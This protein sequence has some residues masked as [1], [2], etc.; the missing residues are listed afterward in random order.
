[1]NNRT[2]SRDDYRVAPTARNP[3][4]KPQG[5]EPDVLKLHEVVLLRRMQ[6]GETQTQAAGAL[7]MT[8]NQATSMTRYLRVR[9]GVA[10]NQDLLALPRVQE[11]L[12]GDGAP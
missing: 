5:V 8:K 11:Q 9:F 6:A 1:M 7:G 3:W 2:Y 4:R 12:R 10:T